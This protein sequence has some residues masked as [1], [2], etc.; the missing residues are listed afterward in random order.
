MEHHKCGSVVQRSS[1]SKRQTDTDDIMFILL[2]AI[3]RGMRF[4]PDEV[5]NA[6]E[7]RQN[8]LEQYGEEVKQSFKAVGL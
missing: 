4:D 3:D 6:T 1:E 8:T 7:D 5:P 2:L